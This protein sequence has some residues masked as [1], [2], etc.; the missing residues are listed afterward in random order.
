YLDTRV[1]YRPPYTK[2][3]Y[4][5]SNW[6]Y[7]TYVRTS[8]EMP[9]PEVEGSLDRLYYEKRLKKGGQSW[10]AYRAAG[11]RAGLFAESMQQ[12][13]NFPKHGRSNFGT[14]SVLLAL[15]GLL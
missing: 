12:L 14:V 15:S 11:H 5:W 4:F 7:R 1:V 13:H 9:L 3:N 6:S 2:D 10:E 8:R